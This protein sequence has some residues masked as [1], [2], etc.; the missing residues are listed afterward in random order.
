MTDKGNDLQAKLRRLGVVKGTRNLKPAPPPDESL[1][2]PFP[3]PTSPSS[4]RSS[5]PPQ[6][7][8]MFFPSIRL[9]ETAVGACYVLDKVYPLHHWHGRDQLQDLLVFQ[10]AVAAPFMGHVALQDAAFHD[11]LFLDTE[12]TGLAGAGTLAFMVGTAFFEG[13]ALVVRQYFLRDHGDEPAMLQLL[14]ELLD[15]KAGLITFNGRSFDVP[16][17]NGRFL[18][19]R[20]L[21]PLDDLP[22]LDLLPPARRLWRARLGS[23][24][25]SALEPSLL[26]H[27]RTQEDVPGWLIPSLY[28]DY[29]RTGDAR[30]LA[31]VF[32]H[33][34][35]DMVSMVTLT[36]RVLR[37]FHAPA[38]SEH[39]IDLFS[40]GKWQADLGLV[41]TAEQNLR[42]A[43]KGDLPLDI[44]HQ[45]LHRLALLLKQ[46]DRRA[47]AVPYWQQ[48]A[49]TSFDDVTAHVEL[50]KYYEWHAVD[51]AT[52][53]QWTEQ[54]LALAATWG[55]GAEPV[56]AELGHRLARLQRKQTAGDDG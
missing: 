10:P 56:R 27:R 49:A 6:A 39:P 14:V 2:R 30:E 45:T 28:H 37:L 25:L 15:Q 50:A 40:V 53:V 16:L 33:N 12:T 1:L 51:I 11:F 48:I 46:T 44:Y 34:Q 8:D 17:L 18:M 24:A 4:S 31:R 36:S 20:M 42:R 5:K 52:A 38:E 54:A 55:R 32:Y 47:E 26:G 23:C 13:E 7:I 22:H 29:L 43:V 35:H 21:P 9:E 19:N 3:K 41:E